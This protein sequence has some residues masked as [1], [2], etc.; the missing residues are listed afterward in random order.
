MKSRVK[1]LVKLGK[2]SP[3]QSLSCTWLARTLGHSSS[4]TGRTGAKD[5]QRQQRSPTGCVVEERALGQWSWNL[6]QKEHEGV[7]SISTK[8]IIERPGSMAASRCWVVAVLTSVGR[9]K[10]WRGGAFPT[11]HCFYRQRTERRSGRTPW[12]S[13]RRRRRAG[14]A[15]RWRTLG[16][17]ALGGWRVGAG[18]VFECGASRFGFAGTL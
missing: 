11:S 12:V 4:V 15:N 2:E 16:S 7:R 8:G 1:T 5:H 18:S 9:K 17:P 3:A 13:N 14:P 10:R 6:G